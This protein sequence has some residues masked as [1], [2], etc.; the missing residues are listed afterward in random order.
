MAAF[1]EGLR[2]MIGVNLG[3]NPVL[4]QTGLGGVW[5]F[6][7]RYTLGIIGPAGTVGERL[8]IF[9]AVEKQLGLKLEEKQVPMPVLVV[10]R[11]NQKPAENPPGTAEAFPHPRLPSL[12]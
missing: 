9:E 7:I 5:N 6:D 4:D 10:E 3:V 2:G 12:K 11:V 8:T 1:A